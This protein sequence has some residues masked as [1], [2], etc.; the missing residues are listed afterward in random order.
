[1]VE[2]VINMMNVRQIER[3]VERS[4]HRQLAQRI[5]LN[6]RCLHQQALERLT[7]PHNVETAALGLALQRIVELTYRPTAIAAAVA[8]Q[9]L[10]L[11]QR[12]GLFGDASSASVASSAAAVR[13]LMDLA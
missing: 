1:M 5:L 11:Q 13:G 4:E 12:D 8:K 3:L 7:Q 2:G 9:L 10:D 6:G